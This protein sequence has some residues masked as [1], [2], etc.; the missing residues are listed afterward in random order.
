VGGRKLR[1]IMED[2]ARTFNSCSV[3][4]EL[5]ADI[6]F[7]VSGEDPGDY[8]FHIEKGKCTF[9]EGVAESSKITIKTPSEVWQA[10]LEGELNPQKAFFMQKFTV[11]GD[12]MLMLQLASLFKRE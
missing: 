4:N 2:I 12:L 11:E 8:Y 9:H 3:S 1:S 10:I 6:Q 7:H 5:V